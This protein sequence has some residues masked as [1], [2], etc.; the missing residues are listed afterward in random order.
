MQ[1]L[2]C[3]RPQ[4]PLPPGCPVRRTHCHARRGTS[5]QFVWVG[6]ETGHVIGQTHRRYRSSQI[7]HCLRMIRATLPLML[8]IHLVTHNDGTHKTHSIRAWFGGCAKSS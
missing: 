4:L 2:D 5:S 1:A 3:T 7:R 6:M 8:D